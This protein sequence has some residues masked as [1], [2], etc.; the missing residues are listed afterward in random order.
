MTDK[1]PTTNLPPADNVLKFETAKEIE[2]IDEKIKR[3]LIN[4]ASAFDELYADYLQARA[5]LIRP[6]KE[7]EDNCDQACDDADGLTWRIIR[8]PAP[9]PRHLDFKFEIMREIMEARFVDGRARALLE[10]IRND[11]V[12]S[13]SFH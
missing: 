3:E 12:D 9:L 4:E 13:Q 8:T 10:S 5:T 1:S 11:V 2:S 7:G 6:L